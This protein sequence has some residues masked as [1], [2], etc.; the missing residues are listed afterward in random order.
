MAYQF[1]NGL[2]GTLKGKSS[3]G[4]EITLAG[5]NAQDSITPAISANQAYKILSIVGKNIVADQNMYR[6]VKEEVYEDE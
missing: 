6:T 2:V 4:D 1:E 3:K 5:I